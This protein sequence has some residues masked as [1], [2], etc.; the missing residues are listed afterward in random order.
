M[1]QRYHFIAHNSC[2]ECEVVSGDDGEWVKWEDVE[3]VAA[4]SFE[5][6]WD[7]CDSWCGRNGAEWNPDDF[8]DDI[9]QFIKRFRLGRVLINDMTGEQ[10]EQIN[11][12]GTT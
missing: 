1:I 12:V 7:C 10:D 2:P 4:A 6:G 11:R 9:E 8:A 5:E 3:A